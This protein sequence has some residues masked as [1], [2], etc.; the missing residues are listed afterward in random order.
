M[1]HTA[2]DSTASLSQWLAYLE[3][4]HHSTIDMGLD[5]IRVVAGQLALETPYIKIT[6]AGTNGK[7]SVCAMLEA[8]LLAAGYKTGLYTSPHLIDF[9]ERIRING[10]M[11]TDQQI[12]QQFVLIEKARGNV[13]LSYF[14]YTTLAALM[15]FGQQGVDVAVLE[16]GLGGRLDAVNLVDADCAIITSIDIDHTEYL[17][18]TREKIGL[19]KA[20]VFRAGQPAICAD[21]VPPQTVVDYAH[22]I[23]ADLWLFGTDFNYSGDRQQWAFGGRAQRRSGLAYP[24]L[25]G[26]NQLLNASAALAAIEALRLKLLVPQQAV[27]VGLAQVALPGRLQILPG[28]PVIVLDVAHN[29][30]AAAALGQNLDNMSTYPHTHAVVGMFN[31]KDVASVIS[32]LASRVDHWYCAGLPGPRGMTGQQLAEIV[33]NVVNKSQDQPTSATTVPDADSALQASTPDDR[34]RPGVRAVPRANT[35]RE[36]VVVSSFDDPVQAFAQAQKQASDN[37]RILVF[38]SFA[39]VGPVLDSLGRP[40]S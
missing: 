3:T 20:H 23:G 2:P 5:R 6:V 11:A 32:R 37:D 4:L 38:G 31:D 18:D 8:I 13:S 12:V 15:L 30:H 25:R 26:A 7:G 27:R 33:Q 24:A 17:G 34:T 14:E 16:V 10:E 9:N 21:P 28:T 22:E 40:A 1:S 36:D 35:P 29:Q 39:T 19:E